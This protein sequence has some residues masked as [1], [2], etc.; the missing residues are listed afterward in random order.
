MHFIQAADITFSPIRP[1][2][3]FFFFVCVCLSCC[4]SSCVL[5]LPR[6]GSR[7][8][9]M[10]VS[11]DD[12]VNNVNGSVRFSRSC[13]CFPGDLTEDSEWCLSLATSLCTC[14]VEAGSMAL[15]NSLD[16]TVQGLVVPSFA[17]ILPILRVISL[18]CVSHCIYSTSINVPGI[19]PICTATTGG[20]EIDSILAPPT[21]P[22]V[23][24]ID[25]AILGSLPC[26]RYVLFNL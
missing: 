7:S 3:F 6:L 2:S 1:H 15:C 26:R 22:P 24:P 21:A 14:R 9:M 12:L 16:F 4:N 18:S 10:P 13:A 19:H 23:P 17:S 20:H 25:G 8:H 11:F 5:F